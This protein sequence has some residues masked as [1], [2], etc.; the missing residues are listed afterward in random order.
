MKLVYFQSLSPST[1]RQVVQKKAV[2]LLKK[3]F[4]DSKVLLYQFYNF[5]IEVHCHPISNRIKWIKS[6]SSV[7]ELEP[8]LEDIQLPNFL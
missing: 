2:L 1:Q 6:F 5:Y 8:Y 7:E 4:P 3:Q